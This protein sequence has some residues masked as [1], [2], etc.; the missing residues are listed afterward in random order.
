MTRVAF[1]AAPYVE[2]DARTGARRRRSALALFGCVGDDVVVGRV[3][4]RDGCVTRV[5]LSLE[6]AR[7]FGV[8]SGVGGALSVVPRDLEARVSP[9]EW[10]EVFVE[11]LERA[12]AAAFRGG[13]FRTAVEYL[14]G[15]A[16]SGGLCLPC[17]SSRQRAVWQRYDAALRAWMVEANARLNPKGI[18]VKPQSNCWVWRN[19]GGGGK[20][21]HIET[22]IAIAVEEAEIEELK[23]EPFLFGD[24]AD[25]S[26]YGGPNESDFITHPHF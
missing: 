21:R 1:D 16:L 2:Y 22:W 14:V 24:V 4:I 9:S 6:R 23:G 8:G 10:T 15:L 13:F 11:G 18:H 26:W 20:Q 12:S 3:K 17:L 7:C 5:N 19:P 25:Y